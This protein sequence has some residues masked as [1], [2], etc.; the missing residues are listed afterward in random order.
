MIKISCENCE[1]WQGEDKSAF[2][3]WGTANIEVRGCPQHLRELFIYLSSKHKLEK[4]YTACNDKRIGEIQLMV[5]DL[6]KEI[7]IGLG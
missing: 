2:Y 3:R 1:K 5:G 7:K 6:L 4:I